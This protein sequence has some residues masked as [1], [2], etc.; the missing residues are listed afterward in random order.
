MNAIVVSVVVGALGK[1]RFQPVQVPGH[2]LRLQNGAVLGT[3]K[4]L[5]FLSV[6]VW[7]RTACRDRRRCCLYDHQLAYR[8]AL[9]GYIVEMS[10]LEAQEQRLDEM[11]RSCNLQLKHMTE[12][13]ENNT[14]AH[15]TYHDIRKINSFSRDT[16]IAIKAPSETRLEVPDPKEVDCLLLCMVL[17]LSNVLCRCGN[18][19]ILTVVEIADNAQ[20]PQRAN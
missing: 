3:D 13:K 20:E 18:P 4:I 10:Q 8:M 7:V 2:A 6:T 19:C 5:G 16:V 12:E 15:V 14:L 1:V 9:V 11:I 17:S